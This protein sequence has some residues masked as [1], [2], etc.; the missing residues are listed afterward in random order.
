MTLQEPEIIDPRAGKIYFAS[1]FHLG[2]PNHDS[3]LEREKLLVR[4]L[5]DIRSD[6]TAIYLMGDVFDFWFEYRT[7]VQKG[8][9]RLLGKLAEISDSGI[10]I[11]LF[12]GNHDIWAFNYLSNEL[13]I[14]LHRDKLIAVLG[15]KC[16][17]LA[18]GDGRGPG[19]KSYKLM[20]KVFESRFNQWLFRW[21]HPDIGSQ[22]ARFFSN[23]SRYANE[24]K[25]EKFGAPPIEEEQLYKY[26]LLKAREH[27]EV[28]IFLFGHRHRP[29]D[30]SINDKARMV[31]LGDWLYHFT[32]A[33]FDGEVLELKKFEPVENSGY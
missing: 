12:K 32:Y 3:S 29:M 27:P 31:I 33:V 11:H 26:C 17:F 22:I 18:H 30:V 14:H 15:N 24:F 28:D 5:E 9:I 25:Q 19:D 23:K 20:K 13:N 16:F 6:A 2:I 7:V 1:D 21:I 4:W 10:P 8:Y